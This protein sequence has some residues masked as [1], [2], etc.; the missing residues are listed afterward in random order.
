MP[1]AIEVRINEVGDIL[2]L[3]FLRAKIA[4][5][6]EFGDWRNLDYD[7]EGRL[8]GVELIGL[9]RGVSLLGLPE[10]D[11]IRDALIAHG[12]PELRV[13]GYEVF[14]PLNEPAPAS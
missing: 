12:P 13:E 2:Y 11:R 14:H 6:R 9:P 7:G 10:T 5:C 4:T 3:R 1:G 8:I